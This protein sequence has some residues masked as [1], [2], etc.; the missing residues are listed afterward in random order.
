MS[1]AEAMDYANLLPNGSNHGGGRCWRGLW[2]GRRRLATG[3][4]L[5]IAL[6][7]FQ[8]TVR[9]KHE[10]P[11][12]AAFPVSFQRQRHGSRE[13]SGHGLMRCCPVQG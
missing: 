1:A 6:F 10:T 4:Y 12:E 2:Q 5:M 3:A 9:W 13:R 11:T 8:K 7:V